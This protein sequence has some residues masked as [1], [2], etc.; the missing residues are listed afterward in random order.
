VHMT[1]YHFL[2]NEEKCGQKENIE[3]R[4]KEKK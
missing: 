4:E 1:E 2:E 3:G